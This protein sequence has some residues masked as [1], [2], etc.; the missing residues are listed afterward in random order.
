MAGPAI[1]VVACIITIVLAAQG[2]NAQT[3][4]DGGRRQGLVVSRPVDQAEPAQQRVVAPDEPQEG[5]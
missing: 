3:I 1:A 4:V 2:F 5:T